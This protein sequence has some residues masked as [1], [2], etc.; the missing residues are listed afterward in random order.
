LP[1][2]YGAW[3]VHGVLASLQMARGNDEVTVDRFDRD[4]R[5]VRDDRDVQLFRRREVDH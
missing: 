2:G 4:G 5:A 3:H 1:N